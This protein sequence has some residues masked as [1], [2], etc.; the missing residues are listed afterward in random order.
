M[1][2]GGAGRV[3]LACFA[4]SSSLLAA[5]SA[6]FAASLAS[7]VASEVAEQVRTSAEEPLYRRTERATQKR[8][9][10]SISSASLCKSLSVETGKADATGATDGR[11]AAS[12]SALCSALRSSAAAL[13][14]SFRS[15]PAV[16]KK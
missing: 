15:S 9:V 3:W 8:N 4:T 2:T 5:R 6:C 16:E 13:R 10:P 1:M 12:L 11:L 7:R 14:S